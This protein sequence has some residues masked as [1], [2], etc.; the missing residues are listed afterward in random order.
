MVIAKQITTNTSN[1]NK[2]QARIHTHTADKESTLKS[3]KTATSM[4]KPN[5][6]NEKQ[7][8]KAQ[9]QQE[10]ENNKKQDAFDKNYQKHQK[11]EEFIWNEKNTMK[12][13]TTTWTKIPERECKAPKSYTQEDLFKEGD[14]V[15]DMCR[16]IHIKTPL[17]KDK[18]HTIDQWV[19]LLKTSFQANFVITQDKHAKKLRTLAMR[20]AVTNPRAIFDGAVWKGPKLLSQ[21]ITQAWVAAT[22]MFGDIWMTEAKQFDIAKETE[23]MVIDDDKDIDQDAEMEEATKTTN[24]KKETKADKDNSDEEEN[25][26]AKKPAEVSPEKRAVGFS[27]LAKKPTNSF[28]LVKSLRKKKDRTDLENTTYARKQKVYATVRLPKITKEGDADAEK[29][30]V[31]L[32]NS[33]AKRFFHSDKRTVILTWNESK[34]VKPLTENSTLPKVRAQMEQFVDRVFV[35]Y[36]KAAYC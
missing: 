36:N 23:E 21:D 25:N 28:F 3:T 27:G 2:I 29:E 26:P 5:K 9:K 8:A 13:A 17:A 35:E 12:K 33:M 31:E 24:K 1:N 18:K 10:E 32:F 15:H 19:S 7:G 34:T 22:T 6:K 20:M 11:N 4:T 30:V 16:I 14:S